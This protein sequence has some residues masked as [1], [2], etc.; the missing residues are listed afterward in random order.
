MR[1]MR[2]RPDR[3]P[4]PV[5]VEI[6]NP[7]AFERSGRLHALSMSVQSQRLIERVVSRHI[8]PATRAHLR[9]VGYR[10]QTLILTFDSAAFSARLRYRTDDLTRKLRQQPELEALE[11]IRCI[12]RPPASPALRERRKHTR[13]P[14]QPKVAQML[15][16]S[17]ENFSDCDLRKSLQRL[18]KRMAPETSVS[19]PTGSLS[20]PEPASCTK[21][22]PDPVRRK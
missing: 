4:S 17:A 16:D 3:F 21:S 15:Q 10:D 6:D 14:A 22:A 8:E 12:V 18:A 20:S 19:H 13:R 1:N 2:T 11:S 7:Q 9:G 5:K